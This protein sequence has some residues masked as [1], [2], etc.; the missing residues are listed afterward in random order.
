MRDPV[1]YVSTQQIHCPC[2]NASAGI[3]G[4][5]FAEIFPNQS[6][7]RLH[8]NSLWSLS[9]KWVAKRSFTKPQTIQIFLTVLLSNI[10]TSERNALCF[11]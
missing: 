5:S 1:R 10:P 6:Q 9:C 7:C 4:R 2:I 3:Q 11:S 8:Q